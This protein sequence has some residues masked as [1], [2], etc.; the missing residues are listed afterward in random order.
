M[1]EPVKNKKV[2]YLLIC[3]V[4]GVWG[5]IV[6][7]LFLKDAGEDYVLQNAVGKQKHEPFDQ[8]LAKPDTFKLA[9]QYR[10]PFLGEGGA[11]VVE[12]P[13]PVN[14][15]P[16]V[17][18]AVI[19]PPINWGSIRYMGRF[20]NS[21]SKKT[22]VIIS[23]NGKEHMIENGVVFEGVKLLKITPDS[24]LVSWQGKQKYIKQ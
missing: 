21:G 6:Y 14:P 20:V 19:T 22:V 5:V 15:I 9:L 12:N 3:A 1:A 24:I 4:A 18:P 10:D 13:G 2:V 11:K 7:Q 23:L 17:R 8:Y 16:M